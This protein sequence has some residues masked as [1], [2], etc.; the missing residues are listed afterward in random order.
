MRF[1]LHLGTAAVRAARSFHA[2]SAAGWADGLC[3]AACDPGRFPATAPASAAR[4]AAFPAQPR[5]AGACVPPRAETPPA[6]IIRVNILQRA[7]THQCNKHHVWGT[8][9]YAQSPTTFTCNRPCQSTCRAVLWS[10]KRTGNWVWPWGSS[11]TGRACWL[12]PSAVSA[13]EWWPRSYTR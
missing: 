10:L 4:P 2:P 1:D 12:K 6:G 8:I 13:S 9:N 5:Q 7:Y 11:P 3:R